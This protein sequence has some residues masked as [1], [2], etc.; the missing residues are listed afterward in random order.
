MAELTPEERESLLK[1]AEDIRNQLKELRQKR[2]KEEPKVPGVKAPPGV[3]EE[4]L[5][6]LGAGLKGAAYGAT[7]GAAPTIDTAAASIGDIFTGEKPVLPGTPEFKQKVL[8][9]RKAYEQAEK[10]YPT[11]Y[12]AGQVLG[13]FIPGIGTGKAATAVGK[14]FSKGLPRVAAETA[15]EAGAGAG[16]AKIGEGDALEGAAIG[17]L[18]SVGSKALGMVGKEVFGKTVLPKGLK[19]SAIEDVPTEFKGLVTEAAESPQA[20]KNLQGA[21]PRIKQLG[22]EIE[23]LQAELKIKQQIDEDRFEQARKAIEQSNKIKEIDYAANLKKAEIEQKKITE[24]AI[25]DLKNQRTVEAANKI[26]EAANRGLELQKQ[27]AKAKYNITFNRMTD[28]VQPAASQVFKISGV[29][30]KVDPEILINA[31]Q[32]RK[33]LRLSSRKLEQDAKIGAWTVG[34]D[35]ESMVSM[36]QAI[37]SDLRKLRKLQSKESAPIIQKTI[38]ELETAQSQLGLSLNNA[39]KALPDELRVQYNEAKAL[40]ADY[41]KMKDELFAA[42]LIAPRKTISGKKQFEATA[43]T[44]EKFLKTGIKDVSRAAKVQQTLQNLPGDLEDS[45]AM[46]PAE[47]AQLTQAVSTRPTV[48][49][50]P[51]NIPKPELQPLPTRQVSP[52]IPAIEGQ[53]A[54]KESQ[55]LKERPLEEAYRVLDKPKE[56]TFPGPLRYL[57]LSPTKPLT[58]IERAQ[59]IEEFGKRY[60]GI[61]SF[62]KM[63]T[64]VDQLPRVLANAYNLSQQDAAKLAESWTNLISQPFE[65]ESEKTP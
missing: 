23:P 5:G 4:V 18:G 44:G 62:S 19:E 64:N 28:Q 26:A 25:E 6:G 10:D 15:V 63:V 11:S 36:D 61:A 53:I 37:N 29:L 22:R 46:T 40:Y 59:A 17:G 32:T 54:A 30:D 48:D 9:R 31:E 33:A 41:A 47:F 56:S 35:F 27:K 34:K 1:E 57:D 21:G 58:K 65:E 43:E 50:P 42:K 49:I 52:E 8:E 60:P 13:A 24:A 55:I 51:V 20:L 45:S 14:A 39:E 16:L 7:M 38:D 12:G 3:V 2:E